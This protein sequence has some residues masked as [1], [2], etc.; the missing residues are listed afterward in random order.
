[1]F[2]MKTG[3]EFNC[4][5]FISS[6]CINLASFLWDMGK[7]NSPDV[8]PLNTTSH[9]GLFCLL[10]GISSKNEIIMKITPDAPI[11]GYGWGLMIGK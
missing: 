2:F 7:Q 5:V 1:M 6:E 8:T 3:H 10:I 4:C 11:R 9:L